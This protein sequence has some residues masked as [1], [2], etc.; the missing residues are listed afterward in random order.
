MWKN[1]LRVAL[2]NLSR[3]RLYSIINIV[4]LAIGLGGCLLIAGVIGCPIAWYLSNLRLERF[5]CRIEIGPGI[6]LLAG[7]LAFA[8]AVL[9]VLVQSLKAATANPVES[10][11]Y[12]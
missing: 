2:R 7:G 6:F 10:L 4:G 3:N 5:V 11:K 9:S 12:E 8:V 1:Y